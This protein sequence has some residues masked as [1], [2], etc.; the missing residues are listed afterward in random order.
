MNP[1]EARVAAEVRRRGPIPFAEVIDLALYDPDHGFYSSGGSAGRRGDFITSPEVGPLFGAV[2][3]RALDTWWTALGRPDPYVVVAAGAGPGT[4]ARSIL[5]AA[6]KCATALRYV[7]VERAAPLRRRHRDHLPLVDAEQFFAPCAGEDSGD[8][9]RPSTVTPDGP[10]VVSRAD[11][12]RVEGPCVV[13]ANELLDNLAF[14]LWE[15]RFGRWL[16]VRVDVDDCVRVERLVPAEHPTWFPEAHDGAR[17]PQ[18]D[19]AAAWLTEALVLAGEGRVVVID[20]AAT[21]ASLCVRPW[22]GW[23]RTY[24]GHQRGTHPLDGLGRQDVT[25][26]VALDQLARVRHPALDRAQA[27]FL[28]AHGLAELVAEGRRTWAE[29]AHLGDLAALRARSRIGEAEALGD[30]AGLGG[31]RVLEWVGRAPRAV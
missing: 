12:P 11:M 24:R 16:D 1:L 21:T 17:A 14:G 4:L 10:L 2:L 3:A 23:V 29:R 8:A 19:A 5:A 28:A 22:L 26:E 20:Y 6:P 27:E 30:P 13:V 7:R 18:Q 9:A 25:V 31:F 15:R